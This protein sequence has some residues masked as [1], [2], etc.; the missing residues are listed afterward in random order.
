MNSVPQLIEHLNRNLVPPEML[1]T[2]SIFNR[3]KNE[4]L[5]F[6]PELE[7]TDEQG[8]TVYVDEVPFTPLLITLQMYVYEH[9]QHTKADVL[10]E[11]ILRDIINTCTTDILMALK[12]VG[13]TIGLEL[14]TSNN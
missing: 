8:N 10:T 11:D 6:I 9:L 3:Y 1:P 2:I 14:K 12:Q 7:D 4:L 13:N 5:K